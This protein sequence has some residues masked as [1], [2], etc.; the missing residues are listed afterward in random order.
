MSYGD[1]N[2]A[3]TKIDY[4]NMDLFHYVEKNEYAKIDS[5]LIVSDL[6]NDLVEVMRVLEL[7]LSGDT[8]QNEF[9]ETFTVFENKW[10]KERN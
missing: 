2:Y 10:I 9:I 8:D 7:W 5:V 6:L 1:L 4:I 3:Y